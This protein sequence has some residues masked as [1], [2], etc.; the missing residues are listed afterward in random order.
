MIIIDIRQAKIILLLHH[1]YLSCNLELLPLFFSGRSLYLPDYLVLRKILRTRL[2]LPRR[3]LQILHHSPP[4]LLS[5]FL[6]EVW[7]RLSII[8]FCFSIPR[9]LILQSYQ[10]LPPSL[11]SSPHWWGRIKVGGY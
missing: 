11:N 1:Y 3:P 10:N 7:I 4:L 9:Q 5:I 2:L 6:F 8:F